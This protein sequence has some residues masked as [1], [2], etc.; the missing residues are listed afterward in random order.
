MTCRRGRLALLVLLLA[1]V[2]APAAEVVADLSSHLIAITTGFTGTSVVLFGATDGPGDVVAVVRGPEHDVRIWRKGKI[3][4]IWANAE[5][6]TFANVPSFYAVAASRPLDQL[7]S[8]SA[9]A[10]YG[11][12]AVNLGL[13]PLSEG[14]PD[15]VRRF[16]EALIGVE[17]RAGIFAAAPG[18]IVFLGD[19][20]FRTTIGFP[21]NVPTGSYLV[22]V[23]LVRDRDVVSAQTTP[24]VVSKIGIDAAV[25]DIA[26]RQPLVYGAIAVLIAAMAGWLASLP[27]RS[28]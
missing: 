19:R 2:P 14:V 20:L 18:K 8:P 6:V 13:R 9:A 12:G 22:Q 17:Q 7:L 4:G 21:A 26:H 23:F 28:R 10:L 15:R 27:F 24:L 1:P 5:S 16:A 11:I 3:A 25:F